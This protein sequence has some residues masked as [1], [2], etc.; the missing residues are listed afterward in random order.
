MKAK[1][2]TLLA[3]FA[4]AVAACGGDAN[5]TTTEAAMEDPMADWPDKV[6]FGFIPS[7]R[8]E[9]LNDA[10]TPFMEYLSETL[11]IE[12]EGIVT[13]DYNGLV[14]AMGTGGADF[15]AF[16][17]LGY[18]QAKDQYP[19]IIVLAQSVRFGSDLYHGQWF[20]ADASICDSEPVIGGFENVN[21]VATIL[22]VTEVKALQ[23][24]WQ[25]T[26]GVLGPET[27]E[28]G[29]VVDQGLVCNASLD[30]VIGKKIAFTSATSTSGTVYPQ[31]QLLNLG[32]DIE[33][34]I[35]YE[36]LGSHDSAVAAVYDGS[37]DI[38]LSFDDARRSLRNENPDI[39]SKVIVFNI[40]ADIPNDVVAANGDL[41]PLL[42]EDMFK[43]ISAYLATEEGEAVL[44]EIYGWTDIREAIESDFDVVREAVR[45]L[46]ISES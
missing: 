35:T 13:A 5:P 34:D 37:F 24:G 39:G 7:E 8:A 43:A 10:I 28:D 21:G 12:V 27:L 18:V 30:K 26:D 9:T 31:L 46:G 23:V 40:T 25:Y 6:I 22:D 16:G 32:I 44:D 38:G 14:V 33:N 36:Y 41:P 17:P 11:G 29:T 45:K 19:S 20:T 2:F 42:L 1:L 4:L 3:V 15:G